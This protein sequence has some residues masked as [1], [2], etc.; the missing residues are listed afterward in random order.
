VAKPQQIELPGEIFIPIL[1][2]DRS[3]LAID[4]PVGWMLAP[5]DWVHTGRNLS[6]ALQSSLNA[7]D[8]WARSRN[9]KFLRAVHRLDAD[10][11]GVLLLAKSPGAVST[12][13]R[14]FELRTMKK[15]Y[16][17]IVHGAPRQP[18]WICRGKIGS[19][20]QRAG[21]MKIDERYGKDA[22][23]HFRVLQSAGEKTLLEAQ[24]VTGRTHQIRIHLEAAGLS[25]LG[26]P[27]YGPKN[28]GLNPLALRAVELGYVDPFLKKPVCI[29][30]PRTAF[31]RDFGL[32][33]E[34]GAGADT[35]HFERPDLAQ[36]QNKGQPP[37]RQ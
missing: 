29:R 4:K 37:Q 17:A 34:S 20:S 10:T 19:D 3:V 35:S 1:Y 24:P 15:I 7:G 32:A 8:F 22:E 14:L 9:L 30:A 28:S 23:T 33:P 18:D 36:S 31:L 27:I 2:E 12:F 5:D 21:R 11:T 25:I 6:L 13:S 16:W 26:D